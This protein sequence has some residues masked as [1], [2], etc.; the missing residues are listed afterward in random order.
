[1]PTWIRADQDWN[2]PMARF[3]VGEIHVI[4]H[5]MLAAAVA[6]NELDQVSRY[7]QKLFEQHRPELVGG[8]VL[9]I[10]FDLAYREWEFEYTHPSLPRPKFGEMSETWSVVPP[11]SGVD[12]LPVSIAIE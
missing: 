11:T 6:A 12:P 10:R 7:L 9:G 1:M 8:S 5:L 2:V 3:R 4:Q